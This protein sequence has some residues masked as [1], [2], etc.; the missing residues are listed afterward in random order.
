MPL[1][2]GSILSTRGVACL[3]P[4]IPTP[5]RTLGLLLPVLPRRFTMCSRLIVSAA[6]ALFLIVTALQSGAGAEQA[7][8]FFTA[9]TFAVGSGPHSVVIAD[10]NGDGKPDLVTAND[11][12]N[13]VSILLGKVGGEFK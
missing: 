9:R 11:Y 2:I 8:M 10:F 6:V 7:T 3:F 13:D 4:L 12:S 1:I 5:S